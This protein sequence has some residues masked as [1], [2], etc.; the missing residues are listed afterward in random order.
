MKYNVVFTE[1][2]MHVAKIK[3]H[4]SKSRGHVHTVAIKVAIYLD[5]CFIRECND[6]VL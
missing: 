4:S 6:E 3:T 1:L 5:D 2:V